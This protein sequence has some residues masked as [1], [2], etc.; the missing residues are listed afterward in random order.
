MNNDEPFV[1]AIDGTA[2][3]GKGILA[4]NLSAILKI[5]YL[6]TGNL[7]RAAAKKLMALTKNDPIDN[8]SELA[9]KCAQEVTIED[10]KDPSLASDEIAKCASRLASNLKVREFLTDLQKVFAKNVGGLIIEGR[11][12]G[13]VVFPNAQVKIFLTASDASRASRRKL[14]F[15]KN[16]INIDYEKILH[17]IKAR[18]YGDM[19]RAIAPLKVAEDAIMLDTTDMSAEEVTKF[20]VSKIAKRKLI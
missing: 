14:E 4:K 5:D 2:A 12:I 19:N 3:S 16:S 20:I 1:I 13:T 17:D 10:S 9:Y 7:Y 6:C 11:D 15:E 18:D 8:F